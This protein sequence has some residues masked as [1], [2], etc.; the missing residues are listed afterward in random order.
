MPRAVAQRVPDSLVLSE[1][2]EPV[3]YGRL[4]YKS[5]VGGVVFAL[6]LVVVGGL[7]FALPLLGPYLGTFFIFLALANLLYVFLAVL[8]SEYFLSNRRIFVREGIVGRASHDL[9]LEWVSGTLIQQGI[10]ARALNYGDIKFTGPGGETSLVPMRGLSDVLNVKRLVDDTIESNRVKAGPGAHAAPPEA[11]ALTGSAT[12]PRYC[13]KCG[14][15]LDEGAEFCG[16]CGA[17]VPQR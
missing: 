14:S 10:F 5:R 1:G 4:S 9:K 7:F 16:S 11:V 15:L 17:K 12:K 6:I 8:N 2:E 3:W 13:I